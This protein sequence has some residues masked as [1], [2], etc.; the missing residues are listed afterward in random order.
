MFVHQMVVLAVSYD[1]NLTNYG[2]LYKAQNW[3]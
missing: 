1:V 3:H 2:V